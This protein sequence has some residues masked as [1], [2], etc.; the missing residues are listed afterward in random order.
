[1][2]RIAIL[3]LL[4]LMLPF[5]SGCTGVDTS[6]DPLTPTPAPV[7]VVSVE[8]PVIVLPPEL[9]GTPVTLSAIPLQTDH[10]LYLTFEMNA[11]GRQRQIPTGGYPLILTFFVYNTDQ[12]A[13]GYAPSTADEVRN[14]AIPYK[15][16]SL[17]LYSENIL[18]HNEQVPERSSPAGLFYPSRP[19]AY[20]VIIEIRQV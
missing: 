5:F 10:A 3:L 11:R 17:H 7:P 18:T 20:G 12:F 14:S 4:C 6:P 19:Y 16:R 15:T 13:P 8:S 1:M 2:K 9:A